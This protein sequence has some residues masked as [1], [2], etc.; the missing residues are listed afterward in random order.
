MGCPGVRTSESRTAA[1]LPRFRTNVWTGAG[2][3]K[4]RQSSEDRRPGLGDSPARTSVTG[5]DSAPMSTD[6]STPS[7]GDRIADLERENGRLQAEQER[8]EAEL[9]QLRGQRERTARAVKVAGGL[10]GRILA[11]PALWSSS[12]AWFEK[13]SEMEGPR[14]LACPETADLTTAIVQRVVRVGMFGLVVG[15]VVAV[16]PAILMLWQNFLIRDQVQQQVSDMLIVRRAQLLGTIYEEHC[17]DRAGATDA[18][19]QE[20]TDPGKIGQ[21]RVNTEDRIC[22]PKARPRARKEAVLAFFEIE[23]SANTR[24]DLTGADFRELIL[25]NVDLSRATLVDGNF[26]GTHLVGSDLRES[27]LFRA[28][29][30][31]SDLRFS[32]LS[33]AD[34]QWADLRGSKLHWA[35]LQSARLSAANLSGADLKGANLT[36]ANLSGADLRGANLT[37]ANLS[38]SIIRGTVHS[39]EFEGSWEADLSGADLSQANLSGA[40]LVSAYGLTQAQLDSAMGDR[41]TKLPHSGRNAGLKRPEHW[42]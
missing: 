1:H 7:P 41:L 20:M 15:L 38:G 8:L 10:G 36:G 11:G 22:R 32:I 42:K 3:H 5:L 14:D 39:T 34:L 25:R 37:A 23:R 31:S 35:K 12:R 26:S 4:S 13:L 17:E 28:N 16:L 2:H 19:S 6:A 33:G 30:S 27:E 21:A 29:L 40:N 24:P 9:A 18:S